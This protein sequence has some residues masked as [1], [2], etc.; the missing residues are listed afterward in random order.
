MTSTAL[1]LPMSLYQGRKPG[2]GQ[3]VPLP[4]RT[5]PYMGN[6]VNINDF[7]SSQT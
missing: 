6:K 4:T 1:E 2:A 3:L 5:F 7:F